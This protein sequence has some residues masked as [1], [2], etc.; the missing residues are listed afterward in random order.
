M[1]VRIDFYPGDVSAHPTAGGRILCRSC[2]KTVW[3][4]ME[5]TPDELDE[6]RMDHIAAH[7]DGLF[8]DY[9]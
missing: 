9:N 1:V 8:D 3:A 4:S 7:E 5:C 2:G 6:A